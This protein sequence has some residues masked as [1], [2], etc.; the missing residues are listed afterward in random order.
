MR[1]EELDY[2][3]P[4]A[5]IAQHPA[6]VR[7]SSRL[8]ILDRAAGS[9]SHSDFRRLPDWLRP[10]DLLVRNDTRVIPA[11]LRGEREAGGRVEVLLLRQEGANSDGEIW[12]CLARPGRRLRPGERARFA[13]GVV[14]EWLDDSDN[15]GIR[16]IRLR[17]SRPILR[18]L[19]EI[20]EVPLPPYIEHRPSAMR[21]LTRPCTRPRRAPSRHR[22]RGSIFPTRRC[23]R[24]SGAAS[25]REP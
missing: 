16:R 19:E 6:P 5:A 14:G 8:M 17:G 4:R 25:R 12:T 10:D 3:L 7:G 13:A 18:M 15:D 9:W 21:T 22:P 23:E 11:R 24:S 2:E 20:G 1:V